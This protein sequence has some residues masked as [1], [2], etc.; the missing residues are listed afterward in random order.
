MT[1]AK[2]LQRIDNKILRFAQNDTG[3]VVTIVSLNE[4]KSPRPDF[5][6]PVK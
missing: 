2:N 3:D 5:A 6:G 1:R 4:A